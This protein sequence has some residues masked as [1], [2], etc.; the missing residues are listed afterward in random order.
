[1]R[2]GHRSRFMY[3]GAGLTLPLLPYCNL[4]TAQCSFC[5]DGE[6]TQINS[7]G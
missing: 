7:S 4:L 5:S 6:F 1:M 3:T 2:Y